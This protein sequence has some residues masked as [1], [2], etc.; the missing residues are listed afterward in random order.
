M[1][2]MSIFQASFK[3]IIHSCSVSLVLGS[4][5]PPGAVV[6]DASRTAVCATAATS[7]F[8]AF[9]KTFWKYLWLPR[10]WMALSSFWSDDWCIWLL[11]RILLGNRIGG[12]C[13]CWVLILVET[14]FSFHN[15]LSFITNTS[16]IF[17]RV[18]GLLVNI[19][20]F[21][22]M[23]PNLIEILRI[24]DMSRFWIQYED[25]KRF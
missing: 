19:L 9:G 21:F 17:Q 8:T 18:V 15:N 12:F 20:N 22:Y 4:L 16:H 1:E 5:I 13:I 6:F 2:V 14:R 7:C 25:S 10:I 23:W 3:E 11:W 24:N